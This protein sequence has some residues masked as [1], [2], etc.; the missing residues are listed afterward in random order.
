MFEPIDRRSTCRPYA[1]ACW[2]LSGLVG[3]AVLVLA[4]QGWSPQPYLPPLEALQGVLPYWLSL[5]VQAAVLAAMADISWRLQRGL[6]VPD[7]RLGR[8]LA[9]LGA[10]YMIVAFARIA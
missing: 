10:G 8:V 6:L 5:C 7:P 1:R 4:T 2:L 3:A 9:W